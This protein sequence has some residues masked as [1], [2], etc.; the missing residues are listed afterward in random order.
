MTGIITSVQTHQREVPN[1]SLHQE[2]PE[3]VYEIMIDDDSFSCEPPDP[4]EHSVAPV[5]GRDADNADLFVSEHGE[6]IRWCE[7]FQYWLTWDGMR[8]KR[9]NDLEI[10]RLAERTARA[11]IAKSSQFP[12]EIAKNLAEVGSHLL[13]QGK[14]VQMIEASKRKVT[15]SDKELDNDR[16]FLTVQNGVIDLRTGSL[17]PFDKTRMSTRM[18]DIVYD[19][20]AKCPK[21]MEF[22]HMVMGGNEDEILWLQRAIGYSLTGE[23]DAKMFAFLYGGGDNGKSTFL[24]IINMLAGEY[25]QK[26]SIEALLA[27]QR[28]KEQKNTPF[29]AALRGARFVFTDEML[30][31]STL[32][33]SL[34]KDLTGGDTLSGMAKYQDPTTFLPSH[35]L[36]LYGNTKPNI[37]DDSDAMWG[38]VKLV[39]FGVTIPK[40]MRKPLN[41]VKA[42]F[43]AELSGILNWAIDG[44][45]VAYEKG[46][47]TTDSI[48]TETREYRDSEDIVGRW[49][50]ER[51]I[52]SPSNHTDKHQAYNSFRVFAEQEGIR[53]V[54]QEKSLT[55][56]L[57]RLGIALDKGKRN[58]IGIE[59]GSPEARQ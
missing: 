48:E 15:V 26:S 23:G 40:E 16:G 31:N 56:R 41:K 11:L 20:T 2:I 5:V 34:M 12:K 52:L 4:E 30:E 50:K 24:E 37:Q 55:R 47:G 29:T 44:A 14:M 13:I 18:T 28:S 42:M 51:C 17:L 21:W 19:P 49:L 58:Y 9:D 54:P 57:N 33:A 59:M 25:A 53:Q 8:W 45:K 39:K 38:R 1:H 27:G 32:N 46:I 22:L 10:E 6:N 3:I 7:K 35:F 43:R 36:F